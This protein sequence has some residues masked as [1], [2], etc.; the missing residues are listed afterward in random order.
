MSWLHPHVRIITGAWSRIIESTTT[1][2]VK[3]MHIYGIALGEIMVLGGLA[4]VV[5]TAIIIAVSIVVVAHS[6]RDEPIATKAREE[7]G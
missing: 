7:G 3:D 1:Q 4:M 5:A 2:E 6:R